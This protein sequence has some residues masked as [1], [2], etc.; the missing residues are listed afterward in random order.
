MKNLS[1]IVLSFFGIGFLPLGQG[2]IASIVGVVF[3]VGLGSLI[4]KFGFGWL[5][6]LIRAKYAWCI[7]LGLQLA[8]TIILM[9]VQPTSP[10]ALIWA[11]AIVMGLGIG[12]WLPTMSMLVSTHFGLASYGIILGMMVLAQHVGTAVGP[13]MAGY[14]YDAMGTYQ[15]AFITFV[16]LYA[17]AIPAILLV[18]R[19][20]S[21]Q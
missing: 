2:T 8:G 3:F 1:K 11:Y 7:S 10:L 4:G 14:M 13:L 21:L 9:I 5:C 6:D 16:A 20:K 19:P 15:W 17:I 12:G 18:R